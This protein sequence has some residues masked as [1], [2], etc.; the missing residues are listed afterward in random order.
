LKLNFILR[1]MKELANV[2]REECHYYE[3]EVKELGMHSPTLSSGPQP[4]YLSSS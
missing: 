4:F 3:N 2:A 1:K